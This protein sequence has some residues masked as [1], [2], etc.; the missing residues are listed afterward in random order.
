ME[1]LHSSLFSEETINSLRE[2]Y[3]KS[4]PY[5]HVVIKELCTD[6]VMRDVH[7]DVCMKSLHTQYT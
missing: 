5:N 4:V 7:E 3:I 2:Q 6:K 1:V